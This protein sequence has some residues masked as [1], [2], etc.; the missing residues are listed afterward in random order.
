[1]DDLHEA[2]QP[3]LLM[4]RFTARALKE[5]Q[6][7]MIGA[8][9]DGEVRQSPPLSHLIGDLIREGHQIPLG[10]LTETE[11]QRLVRDRAG[12]VG[13]EKLAIELHRATGGNPLFLDGVVRMM[14]ADG[15]ETSELRRT[16]FKL[17]M[18]CAKRSTAG[19][20]GLSKDANSVLS[21]AAVIGQEFEL[22]ALRQ[23]VELPGEKLLELLHEA[24]LAGVVAQGAAGRCRFCHAHPRGGLSRAGSRRSCAA[25]SESGRDLEVLHQKDLNPHLAELAH[26]FRQVAEFGDSDKAN[27]L[28]L[29]AGQIAHDVF[30]Y[31][32]AAS[33]WEAALALTNAN[34]V[35]STRSRLDTRAPLQAANRRRQIESNTARRRLHS[36]R[37]SAR[38]SSR[39]TCGYF[40][41]DAMYPWAHAEHS[42]RS[43]P[44]PQC[45][46]RVGARA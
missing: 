29:R 30:A 34:G 42:R 18:E 44:T 20:A 16:A 12:S 5:A 35:D 3:S 15:K 23:A 9:R 4:M 39:P 8:Y 37:V 43:R 33:H 25:A 38:R 40:G 26:H 22:G 24:S 17:P 2:D 46:T 28:L 45:A 1:V 14:L 19:L 31:E 27:R 36:M 32:E 41:A 13:G 21:I 10:G 7:L 11:V 6:V